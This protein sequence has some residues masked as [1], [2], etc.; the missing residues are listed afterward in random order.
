[1]KEKYGKEGTRQDLLRG[2]K[3]ITVT[4][5]VNESSNKREIQDG[6]EAVT[7]NLR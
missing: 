3:A 5:S 1:M 4:D 6:F 2:R 7:L